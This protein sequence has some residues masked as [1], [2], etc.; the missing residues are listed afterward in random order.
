[1]GESLQDLKDASKEYNLR[2][3]K[4]LHYQAQV[5]KERLEY[6]YRI[7][8]RLCAQ[9]KLKEQRNKSVMKREVSVKRRKFLT[10]KFSH[11]SQSCWEAYNV[12]QKY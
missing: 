7:L 8:D 3:Q 2:T 1:M 9:K 6:E 5:E 10:L 4:V 12:T 11:S